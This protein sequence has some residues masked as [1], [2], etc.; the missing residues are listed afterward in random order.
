M[1]FFS[2]GISGSSYAKVMKVDSYQP[3]EIGV[4][5]AAKLPWKEELHS[6]C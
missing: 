3:R 4:E 2:E 1:Y 6:I 5:C